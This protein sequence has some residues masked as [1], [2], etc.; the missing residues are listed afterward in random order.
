MSCS[1]LWPASPRRVGSPILFL[2]P[3]SH[4]PLSFLSVDFRVACGGIPTEGSTQEVRSQDT[5]SS[6]PH[7]DDP[8]KPQT[9]KMDLLEQEL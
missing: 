6:R 3:N 8:F 9:T 5:R 1:E 7:G 2:T 4:L